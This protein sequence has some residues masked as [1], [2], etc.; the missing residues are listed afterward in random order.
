M[1]LVRRRKNT[2]DADDTDDTDDT[3]EFHCCSGDETLI[4]LKFVY[5]KSFTVEKK[6]RVDPF[7]PCLPTGRR[8]IRVF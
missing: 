8:V 4:D 7:N 1:D 2:D 3:V 6:I 5:V